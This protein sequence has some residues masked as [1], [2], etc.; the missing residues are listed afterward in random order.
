M[1]NKKNDEKTQPTDPREAVEAIGKEMYE[2]LSRG[3]SDA[4][5]FLQEL[6][7]AIEE[8][9][10]DAFGKPSSAASKKAGATEAASKP[11]PKK[12]AAKKAPA[13]KKAVAKKAPAK[14]K[15]AAKKAP[16]K[17]KAA[18]KKAPAKK[19]AAA[20]KAPA[21]KKAAAKKAPAKK[22]ATAKKAPAK[23]A[24]AGATRDELYAEAQKLDIDGRSKMTKAQLQRAI[25][26]AKR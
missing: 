3:F 14:K 17:K 11:A 15:A 4:F 13:K 6:S 19:K 24:A 2:T 7:S 16:A 18:A 22:K 5:G 10:E 21:K 1:A 9:I 20:K 23:K 25:A 12:A 26:K 8:R